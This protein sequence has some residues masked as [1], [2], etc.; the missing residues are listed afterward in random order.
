[1][2]IIFQGYNSLSLNSI[3][4]IDLFWASWFFT[5]LVQHNY[6]IALKTRKTLSYG[7][8]SYLIF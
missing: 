5:F 4:I 3:V 7:L 6:L 8:K 1:M 2:E